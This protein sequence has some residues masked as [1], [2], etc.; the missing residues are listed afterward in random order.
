M[1]GGSQ[2][3]GSVTSP[4]IAQSLLWGLGRTISNEQDYL[5]CK[6][7]DISPTTSP[8][9]IQSLFEELW[10]DEAEDEI[11]LRGQARY[12]NRLRRIN[13]TAMTTAF[14]KE[15][16]IPNQSFHLE[17]PKSGVLNDLSLQ[18]TTRRPP[19]SGEVEIQVHTTGLSFKDV[20]RATSLHTKDNLENPYGKSFGLECSGTIVSIGSD[21]E[22]FNIG[23]EVIA[24]SFA[25]LSTYTTTNAKLVVHKPKHI[26]LEAAATIPLAFVTA[27]YALHYLGRISKGERILIHAASGGVGLAA[28]QIAQLAGAEVFATASNKEKREFLTSLGVKYVMDSRSLDFADEIA[29]LTNGEGIDIVLNT[30]AEETIAKSLSTLRMFGRFI[31][32]ANV[33]N[34]SKLP[35][36]AFQKSLSFFAFDLEQIFQERLDFAKTLFCEVIQYFEAQTLHPLP[37][38]V[39]P[40][41]RAV[42]A[43]NY[44]HQAKH[45]G[46][47]LLSWQEPDVV[48]P[49][50]IEPITFRADCTYIDHRRTQRTWL[51]SCSMVS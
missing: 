48:V 31:D 33:N 35:I 10:L 21:V 46:K 7:I 28:I 12:V 1:T 23:D 30:L 51:V 45:I 41:S 32:I 40:L 34:K 50:L 39:F 22:E 6:R 15:V 49:P 42:R 17:K 2:T 27:Y 24:F 8:E 43:F 29:A 44:I 18:A 25:S 13:P 16:K 37:H 5:H 19:N 36:Q 4:S 11:A 14:Q 38:R 26:S 9:E 3:V 47:F 20:I